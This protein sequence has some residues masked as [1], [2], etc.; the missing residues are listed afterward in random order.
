MRK[1]HKICCFFCV[2]FLGQQNNSKE[3]EGSV[4]G[5]G[6]IILVIQW[7]EGV[8]FI[9]FFIWKWGEVGKSGKRLVG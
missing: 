7:G 4:F 9:Y 3:T 2:R 1:Q 5:G 6:C 8:Y